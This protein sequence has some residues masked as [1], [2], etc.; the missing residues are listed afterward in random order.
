MDIGNPNRNKIGRTNQEPLR[1]GLNEGTDTCGDVDDTG[2]PKTDRAS[3]NRER[4]TIA[5][6]VTLNR[7]RGAK[8]ETMTVDRGPE[9][10]NQKPEAS[11]GNRTETNHST[12]GQ[13]LKQGTEGVDI[14]PETSTRSWYA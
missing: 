4:E 5:G 13:N 3:Q 14:E 2:I 7:S 10:R 11:T 6:T 1:I 9:A 12:K 8:P